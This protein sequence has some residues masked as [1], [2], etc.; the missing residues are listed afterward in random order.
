MEAGKQVSKILEKFD[1]DIDGLK[2]YYKAWWVDDP[3]AVIG[4]VHGLGEHCNRYQELAQ[5]FNKQQYAVVAYDRRG[6]GRSE[7]KLGH[8]N[9]FESLLKEIE[10]LFA[11]AKEMATDAPQLI[12]GHSMGGNLALHYCLENRSPLIG[13]MT[14]APWI[15]LPKPTPPA[16]IALAKFMNVIWPSFSQDNGLETQFLC[17][18]PQVV[19]DYLNDPLVHSRISA[20]MAVSMFEAADKLDQYEGAFPVPALLMHGTA[21]NYTAP[22]GT[23]AFAERVS[24]QVSLKLW[25]GMYHEIHHEPNRHLVLEEIMKWLKGQWAMGNESNEQ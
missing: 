20:R 2:I 21:D 13:C 10:L 1:S 17:S 18:D 16:L 6:H 22:E 7:G 15:R 11:W 23:E 3:I 12:Y 19:Q 24:G 4:I 14:S 25:P 5:F 8:T 9:S